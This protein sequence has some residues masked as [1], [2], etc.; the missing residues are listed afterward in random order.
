MQN[1]PYGIANFRK[2]RLENNLYID[3]TR[4][5]ELLER[6]G[7]NY[8]LF[9]RPR[10]FGKSLWLSTM[11]HYYDEYYSEEFEQ[12]FGDLYIGKHPTKL[13]NNYKILFME[14]SGIEID[15]IEGVRL[16][17]NNKVKRAVSRF[18][19]RYKFSDVAMGK[20]ERCELAEDILEEFLDIV[21]DEKIYLLIDEYDHFANAILAED[22]ARFMEIVGKGGFVRSFYEVV[23]TGAMLGVFDRIFITGVTPIT[24]DSLSSGFN[25]A[26][27]ISLEQDFN[28]L[29]GFTEEELEYLLGQTIF[30]EC[31]QI[32]RDVLR[33]DVRRFYDGYVFNADADKRVYNATL[34]N[35]F[36]KRFDYARCQYP[37]HLLDSNIATD[38][39]K[40][41]M[42]FG[43]GDREENYEVLK[44]FIIEGEISGS[45]KDRYEIEEGFGRDDFLTLLFSLGFITIKD[46]L[47]SRFKF[48]ITNYVI[49]HLYFNYF[50]RELDR[51]VQLRLQSCMIEDMLYELATGGKIEPFVQELDR[52]IKHLANRDFMK[53]D[54][55]HFK[56]IV[57][58]L[59]SYAEFYYVKSENEVENRYPDIML[60]RRKPYE[61]KIKYEYLLELK[62]AQKGEVEE[63]LRSGKDQVRTYLEMEEIRE[64]KGLKA[65]VV[66]GSKDGVV[67]ER[68]EE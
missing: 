60:L 48:M 9:L 40:L 62:W 46:S 35:Y 38:Y 44:E 16:R 1:I 36:L 7:Y 66:V 30:K 3:K 2:L 42:L 20:I 14:F 28:E 55:K 39:K 27:N 24:M 57:L 31:E 10:R 58:T 5:I 22:M 21:S 51:R 53:F 64:R 19:K 67:M 6:K 8:V 4:Y 52:V 37:Y 56:A 54:E 32:D 33:E 17:V 18:L 63:K 41:M 61:E 43:I 12:L 47:G 13:R 23:K 34:I 25:I 26:E 59:L 50:A 68:V 15:N 45:I 11:W 29:C 49:R 65:Y